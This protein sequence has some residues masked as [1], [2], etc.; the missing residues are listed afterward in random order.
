M[1]L[2][3]PSSSTSTCRVVGALGGET[4]VLFFTFSSPTVVSIPPAPAPAP[5]VAE[6]AADAFFAE[7]EDEDLGGG[8]AGGVLRYSASPSVLFLTP[9]CV[10]LYPPDTARS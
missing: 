8:G 5:V 1:T 7:P 4:V 9:L 10:V 6:A 3:L 2:T